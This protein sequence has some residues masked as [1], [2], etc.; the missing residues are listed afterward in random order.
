MRLTLF[1]LAALVAIG[2]SAVAVILQPKRP[3][4]SPGL[5]NSRSGFSELLLYRRMKNLELDPGAIARAEPA[6]LFQQLEARCRECASKDRCSHELAGS[7]NHGWMWND[8]CP[9]PPMLNLLSAL[10]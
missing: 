6:I 5:G 9:N 8:Y 10:R 1:I 3:S 4:D 7:S 2:F